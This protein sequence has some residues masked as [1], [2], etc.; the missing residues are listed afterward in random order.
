MWSP[1]TLEVDEHNTAVRTE[2][3]LPPLFLREQ[4]ELAVL[5]ERVYVSPDAPAW[6]A[7]VV[8]DVTARYMADVDVVH[9]DLAAD[10]V[11]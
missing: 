1:K 7:G 5:I 11:Y 4:V 9:S 6:V 2:P 3:D 10:P 8:R